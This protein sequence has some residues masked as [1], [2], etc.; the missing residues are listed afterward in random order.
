[1]GKDNKTSRLQH[2]IGNYATQRKSTSWDF[3]PT[4]EVR[5]HLGEYAKA[6]QETVGKPK[7]RK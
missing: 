7:S 3:L 1:M 2:F 4:E 6:V 5:K